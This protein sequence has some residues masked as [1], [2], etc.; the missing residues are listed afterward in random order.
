MSLSLTFPS[1]PSSTFKDLWD[2]TGPNWMIQDPL[3]VL[4]P[5]ATLVHLCH[6][7]PKDEDKDTF[8]GRYSAYST[9]QILLLPRDNTCSLLLQDSSWNYNVAPSYD[10]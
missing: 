1:A 8:G 7:C 2:Y 4:I 6:P 3:P 10:A 9:P 5:A